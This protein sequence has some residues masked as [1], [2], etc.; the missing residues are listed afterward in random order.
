MKKLDTCQIIKAY[1]DGFQSSIWTVCCNWQD[2]L[3]EQHMEN[4]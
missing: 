3:V 1:A 2:G 4:Y